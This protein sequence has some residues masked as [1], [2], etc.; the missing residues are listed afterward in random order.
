MLHFIYGEDQWRVKERV[1][2]LAQDFVTR[3]PNVLR[4]AIEGDDVE[5]VIQSLPKVREFLQGG[6]FT[7]PAMLELRQ[8]SVLSEEA[9][10]VLKESLKPAL[11]SEDML[12]MASHRGKTKKTHSLVSWLL[13]SL[14]VLRFMEKV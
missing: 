14:R 11:G 13:K 7:E 5:E 10:K 2:A 8:A 12:V 4:L 6:L 1:D 9:A 3:F